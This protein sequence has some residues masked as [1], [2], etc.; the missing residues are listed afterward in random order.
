MAET[1]GNEAAR[2]GTA[3]NDAGLGQAGPN[4]AVLSGAGPEENGALLGGGEAFRAEGETFQGEERREPSR[5]RLAMC[6][7]LSLLY[8]A[9]RV[10][11]PPS[12]F[13]RLWF[14]SLSAR[15]SCSFRAPT[16]S[17]AIRR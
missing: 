9:L 3:Q 6:R 12:T 17:K 4:E 7:C 11:A 16:S 15:S 10:R 8:R 2:N 1:Q 14:R 13:W 5:P